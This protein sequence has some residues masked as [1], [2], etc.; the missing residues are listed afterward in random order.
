MLDPS[1]Y[2]DKA[3]LVCGDLI[4]DLYEFGTIRRLSREAPV[5]IVEFEEERLVLG[6]GGNVVA[7]L[8]A[9]QGKPI[10]VSVIGLDQ[11]GIQ[12]LE[13]L[14]KINVPGAGLLQ[15]PEYPTTT[16]RRI[17]AQGEQS[18]RQQILRLDRL[19]QGPLDSA[20]LAKLK[21]LA[22]QSLENA[23]ALICA[24]YLSSGRHAWLPLSFFTE[25][26][27]AARQKQ[28]PVIVDSRHRILDFKDATLLTPNRTEAADAV[29]FEL[30][31]NQ[32]LEKAG[33]VIYKKA[34]CQLLLIT[35]GGQGMALFEAGRN[36]Q[37]IP[38]YNLQEV[39]DVSGAGDTVVAAVTLGLL[40]GKTPLEACQFAN[41]A[42]GLVVRKVG[43]A[44]VTLEEI[45]S[46]MTQTST[47]V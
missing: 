3:I 22:L 14:K 5:P 10:P 19:P 8:A 33:A 23:A 9:L 38:A 13:L 34:N 11:P 39:F 27:E 12:V 29:G 2:K 18:I 25:L 41:I 46:H 42:A 45:Q 7:N 17:L 47:N 16:K 35:L 43:T 44:T 24:D 40:A 28:K 37:L 26:M 4:A 1:S 32:D 15:L 21:G 6:G 30:K 31:T 36:M 20:A